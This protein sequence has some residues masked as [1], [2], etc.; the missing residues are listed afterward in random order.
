[1]SPTSQPSS[2][3]LLNEIQSHIQV[4]SNSLFSITDKLT[5]CDDD[6]R[7]LM[8][9]VEEDQVAHIDKLKGGIENIINDI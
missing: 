4:L 6:L 5:G 9:D 3:K 8:N 2:L 7:Y 1:M